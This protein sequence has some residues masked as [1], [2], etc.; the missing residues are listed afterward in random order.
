MDKRTFARLIADPD[1]LDFDSP[2]GSKASRPRGGAPAPAPPVANVRPAGATG[3]LPPEIRSQYRNLGSFET[4]ERLGAG[5]F[6]I[7]CLVR[8]RV[9]GKHYALKTI[10]K[11]LVL[12]KRQVDHVRSER[13]NQICCACRTPFVAYVHTTFQDE[14]NLYMLMEYLAGGELFSQLPLKSREVRLV[15]AQVVVALEAIHACDI[16]HRDLKPENILLDVDGRVKLS[17][18]G[19]SKRVTG[20][21]FTFCGTPDYMAPEVIHNI[22]H[23]KGVDYWALGCLVFEMLVGAAPFHEPGA[24]GK[25]FE[26][27][28]K[29]MVRFPTGTPPTTQ[30]LI[31]R[32]LEKD[33]SKRFGAYSARDVRGHRY[34]DGLDWKEVQ[35]M[36]AQRSTVRTHRTSR[37]P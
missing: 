9:T 12:Q 14:H 17:D 29:G 15:A 10:S 6:G 11:R 37:V 27:I 5:A 22:G 1:G 13:E 24:E 31:S 18:F 21:T 20:R 19:L 4:I 35:V 28:L 3:A 26:R 7:V 8:Y 32:L 23:G 2:P 25:T 16:I 30:D 34:F 33:I 36:T